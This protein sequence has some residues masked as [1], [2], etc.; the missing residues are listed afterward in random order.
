M[1]LLLGVAL[2]GR[3]TCMLICPLSNCGTHLPVLTLAHPFTHVTAATPPPLPPQVRSH[4]RPEFVNRI[5]EFI[6]FQGLRREQI[7]SIV[8]L[9]NRA[10]PA[11]ASAQPLV[12][13]RRP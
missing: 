7:K 3:C 4:F 8:L 9:Q 5:D 1:S 2:G 11:K 10:P 12:A 6:V 13:L